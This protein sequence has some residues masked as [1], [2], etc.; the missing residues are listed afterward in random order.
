MHPGAYSQK[1]F[2]CPLWMALWATKTSTIRKNNYICDAC[3]Q[4]IHRS[5]VFGCG[6]QFHEYGSIA[7]FMLAQQ[8]T[9]LPRISEHEQS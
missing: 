9:T 6:T 4:S 8:A 7:P 2:V 3:W 5:P 1:G